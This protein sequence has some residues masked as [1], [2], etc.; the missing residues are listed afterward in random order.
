MR[1][2]ILYNYSRMD[3]VSLLRGCGLEKIVMP[4]RQFIKEHKRLLG[5]LKSGKPKDLRREYEAQL[6]EYKEYMKCVPFK[7]LPLNIF[8]YKTQ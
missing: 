8:K 6:K 5:V 4:K 3:L 1:R 2:N 7:L